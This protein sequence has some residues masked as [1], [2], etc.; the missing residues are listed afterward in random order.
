M[1]Q[2]EWIAAT[3]VAGFLIYLAI[4]KKLPNYWAMMT[5]GAAQPSTAGG[6][7][8]STLAN[9]A[10][11]AGPILGPLLKPILGGIGQKIDPAGAPVPPAPASVGG[12][13]Q[14]QSFPLMPNLPNLPAMTF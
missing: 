14:A 1:S 3:I 11:L 13:S 10:N 7:A 2:S 9:A 6:G 12:Q 8:T 5:G 4:K